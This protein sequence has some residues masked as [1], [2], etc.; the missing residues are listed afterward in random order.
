MAKSSTAIRPLKVLSS[1]FRL[2]LLNSA[3]VG[4]AAMRVTSSTLLKLPSAMAGSF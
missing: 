4:V 2:M 3:L 1:I